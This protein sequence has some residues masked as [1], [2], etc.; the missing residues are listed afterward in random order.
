MNKF[1]DFVVNKIALPIIRHYGRGN[2]YSEHFKNEHLVSG[3]NYKWAVGFNREV[4]DILCLLSLQDKEDSVEKKIGLIDKITKFD[5]IRPLSFN[6]SEFFEPHCKIY[7]NKRIKSVF[8]DDERKE[9]TDSDAISLF[10]C[11]YKYEMSEGN[12]EVD[13]N[14]SLLKGTIMIV[15]NDVDGGVYASYSTA[16]IVNKMD[17]IGH[18][19]IKLP[20]VEV[21]DKT[22]KDHDYFCYVV[23][24]SDIPCWFFNDYKLIEMND[25]KNKF[26]SIKNDIDSMVTF[27]NNNKEMFLN[28]FKDSTAKEG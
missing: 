11:G 3:N 20:Y 5:L 4:N 10:S 2:V 26:K 21:Y 16:L 7:Q 9:F 17:F 19:K 18:N 13:V 23:R 28:I 22:D 1:K 6:S 8:Y 15:I 14:D 27:V 12:V 25:L 24:Q